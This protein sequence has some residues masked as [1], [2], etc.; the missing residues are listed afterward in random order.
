MAERRLGTGETMAG[1]GTVIVCNRLQL[2]VKLDHHILFTDPPCALIVAQRTTCPYERLSDLER[3]F[4]DM[5][6]ALSHTSRDCCTLVIDVRKGPP[7]RNDEAF[8]RMLNEHIA[9]LVKGFRKEAVLVTTA[10]GRLQLRRYVRSAAA[11]A[12]VTDDPA[13]AFGY[14]GLSIHHVPEVG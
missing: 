9:R 5:E 10:I 1:A 12:L 7:G 13:E 11:Q 3:T 6:H 14:L 4:R 8:E 2:L